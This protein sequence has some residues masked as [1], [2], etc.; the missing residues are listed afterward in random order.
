MHIKT[1]YKGNVK[2]TLEKDE[3]DPYFNVLVRKKLGNNWKTISYYK[4]K[5][6]YEAL[7]LYERI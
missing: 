6:K 3:I 4:F 7:K 5:S 2:V 1:K